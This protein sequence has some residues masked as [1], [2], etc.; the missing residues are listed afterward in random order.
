[1][2]AMGKC[3]HNQN[4]NHVY[5]CM[6]RFLLILHSNSRFDVIIDDNLKPWLIEVLITT[7]FRT[8]IK[9]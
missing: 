4:N 8:E 1:M 5:A 3:I 9:V 2:S 7:F 6:A